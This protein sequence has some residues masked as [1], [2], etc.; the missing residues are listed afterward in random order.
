M[1]TVKLQWVRSDQWL[2]FEQTGLTLINVSVRTGNEDYN[3]SEGQWS[4]CYFSFNNEYFI[5]VING[6]S[7]NAPN[8][9]HCCYGMYRCCELLQCFCGW[10]L[11]LHVK[12]QPLRIHCPPQIKSVSWLGQCW[13]VCVSLSSNIRRGSLSH[14]GQQLANHIYSRTKAPAVQMCRTIQRK[15]IHNTGGDICSKTLE[16]CPQR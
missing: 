14:R 11:R 16:T 4:S 9:M 15:Q 1:K 10:I 7:E 6:Y 3:M 8:Q 12:P 5:L 2:H 13:V